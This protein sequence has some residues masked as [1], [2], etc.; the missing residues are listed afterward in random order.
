MI[1]GHPYV[2][3]GVSANVP[4]RQAV[5]FGAASALVLDVTPDTAA[6]GV[7]PGV[8]AG[9]LHSMSLML[10]NQRANAVD[11][12]AD[13][14]PIA[15]LPSVTPPDMGSFNFARTAQLLADA[16]ALAGA[17]VDTWQHQT[18]VI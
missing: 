6:T 8:V 11:H 16:E 4:V 10:R 15:V 3:G 18:A 13:R 5:A 1:A 9:L 14:H 12:L 7:P 2:D 17:T